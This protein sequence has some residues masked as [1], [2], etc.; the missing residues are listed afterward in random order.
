[1]PITPFT[2]TPLTGTQFNEAVQL[3]GPVSIPTVTIV[4]GV[5]TVNGAGYYFVDTESA[6]ATDDL[7][8]ISGLPDGHYCL[9]RAVSASRVIT[10]Q[11]AIGNLRLENGQPFTLNS[12]GDSIAFRT[13]GAQVIEEG[14]RNVP[15]T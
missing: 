11:H 12:L 6:A 13:R 7:T 8:G 3:W 5:I 4:S 15:I 2:G 1:M 10:L 14:R 9:L